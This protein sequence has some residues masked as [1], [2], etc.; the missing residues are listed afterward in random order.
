MDTLPTEVMKV[1][2][3][4][5]HKL[6]I[7]DLVRSFEDRFVAFIHADGSC[8]EVDEESLNEWLDTINGKEC[9]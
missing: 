7:L 8:Y 3:P 9:L 6:S 1:A 5:N 2:S 4:V